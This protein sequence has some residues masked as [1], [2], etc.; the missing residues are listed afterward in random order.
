MKS[1]LALRFRSSP[2]FVVR[3]SLEGQTEIGAVMDQY[4]VR[5]LPGLELSLNGIKAPLNRY[6]ADETMEV[7]KPA[8][9]SAR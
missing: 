4:F 8:D 3:Y 2:T 5:S 6:C 1:Y 7:A 9:P